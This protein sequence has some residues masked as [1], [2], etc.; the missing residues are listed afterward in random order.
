MVRYPFPGN[1]RSGVPFGIA[2]VVKT[3][4]PSIRDGL[5]T[6]EYS[7][8]VILFFTEPLLQDERVPI[9]GKFFNSFIGEWMRDI[10]CSPIVF[11]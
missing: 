1:K 9:A 5:R 10:Y 3:P 4:M 11:K 2:W 7:L 6:K 8:V